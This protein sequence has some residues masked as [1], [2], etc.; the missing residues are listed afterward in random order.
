VGVYYDHLIPLLLY[1]SI[2][3]LSCTQVETIMYRDNNVFMYYYYLL[4]L[5]TSAEHYKQHIHTHTH[6]KFNTWNNTNKIYY[7]Y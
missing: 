2:C 6:C 3:V 5:E 4:N 7:I 1:S